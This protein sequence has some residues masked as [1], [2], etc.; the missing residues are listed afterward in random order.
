MRKNQYDL[1]TI[2]SLESRYAIQLFVTLLMVM[3]WSALY[4]GG[5]L[6]KRTGMNQMHNFTILYEIP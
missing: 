3:I 5:R 2:W 6:G 4:F 1:R